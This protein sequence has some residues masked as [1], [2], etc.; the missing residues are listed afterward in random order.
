MAKN[1][2]Q[3]PRPQFENDFHYLVS[4]AGN[5]D[6]APETGSVIA[7]L[8]DD[9]R[10]AVRTTLRQ[11]ERVAD[12]LAR[13]RQE[14]GLLI[15]ERTQRRFRKFSSEQRESAYG[16]TD[17]RPDHFTGE[18]LRDARQAAQRK[19][20]AML[21][22]AGID[23]DALGKVHDV[24]ARR[25]QRAGRVTPGRAERLDIMP[26]TE[27]PTKV[28]Q[29]ST[30]GWFIKGPPYDSYFW[31]A[32][33]FY[34]GGSVEHRHNIK[35]EENP[36]TYITGQF[37]HYSRYL[38]KS[39][40]DWDALFLNY[41]TGVG[42]WYH[43]AQP[44]NREIWVNIKSKRSQVDVWLD[45]EFGWSDSWSRFFTRFEISVQ[46]LQGSQ[47]LTN[48]WQRSIEGE[49][50]NKWYHEPL[51]GEN[52]EIWL[53]FTINFPPG[54]VF[55]WI[56]ADDH[57]QCGLNDVSTDARMETEYVLQEVHIPD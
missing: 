45:D 39:A 16:V 2:E 50:D 37:G 55:I 21:R 12:G 26:I 17:F 40:S 34:Y 5:A 53:P 25:F 27:V 30:P 52:A 42:F 24:A 10:D 33:G 46:Q 9:H 8:A 57:R 29:G 3:D 11:G 47:G 18:M 35:V 54:N 23:D 43:A 41:R 6:A 56:I 31:Q 38:N 49:P 44:G 22:R 51:V 14:L 48:H 36:F 13:Y 7:A 4:P 19:S 15:D 20:L 1:N 28:L 32:N